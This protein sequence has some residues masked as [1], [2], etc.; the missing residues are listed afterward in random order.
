MTLKNALNP[1]MKIGLFCERAG[2]VPAQ[3]RFPENFA[4][5]GQSNRL[6]RPEH[7]VMVVM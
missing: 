2:P 4:A 3:R 5:A 7:D 1:E 6:G